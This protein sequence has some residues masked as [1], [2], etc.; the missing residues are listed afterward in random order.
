MERGEIAAKGERLGR[1]ISIIDGLR[2]ALDADTGGAIAENLAGLYGYMMGRLIES[3]ASNDVAIIKEV[4]TLMREI[5]T[6]WDGVGNN[7]G[8]V[9]P[10]PDPG[11]R[12]PSMTPVSA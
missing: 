11:D 1:A 4:H 2:T 10:V 5:K 9:T 7:R 12:P 6:G 3:S 8:R